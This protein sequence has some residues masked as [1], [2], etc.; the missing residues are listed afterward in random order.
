MTNPL[1]TVRTYFATRRAIRKREAELERE[2]ATYNT[3]SA[4][5]DMEAILARHSGHEARE[6]EAILRRHAVDRLLRNYS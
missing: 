1:K 3:P 5:M 6:L 2:L 4:R